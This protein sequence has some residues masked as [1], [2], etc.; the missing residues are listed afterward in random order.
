MPFQFFQAHTS[1]SY[2][3]IYP[4][5]Q[6]IIPPPKQ[7]YTLLVFSEPAPDMLANV[8]RRPLLQAFPAALLGRLSVVPYY[9]LTQELVIDIAEL[10]IGKIAKRLQEHHGMALEF[11][12]LACDLLLTRC[13]QWE[14]GARMIDAI[15]NAEVLP[16]ISRQLLESAMNAQGQDASQDE[17]VDT[18]RVIRVSAQDGRFVHSVGESLFTDSEPVENTELVET[19]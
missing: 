5:N 12:D 16:D 7:R 3:P 18:N 19:E 13:A 15:L 1:S 8:L 2:E 14:S 9:P 17:V 4:M 11:D 6:A 10:K